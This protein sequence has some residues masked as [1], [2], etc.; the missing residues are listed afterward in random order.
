MISDQ[1]IDKIT[2][3]FL[4]INPN[5]NTAVQNYVSNDKRVNYM[6]QM[7]K[8]RKPVAIWTDVEKLN[9]YKLKILFKRHKEVNL[10]FFIHYLDDFYRIGFK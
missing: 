1:D 3:I 8:N 9:E 4:H 2:A 7:L 6:V 10:Q 5:L